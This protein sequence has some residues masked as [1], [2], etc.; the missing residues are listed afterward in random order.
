[1]FTSGIRCGLRSFIFDR[2]RELGAAERGAKGFCRHFGGGKAGPPATGSDFKAGAGFDLASLCAITVAVAGLPKEAAR[3][4][5]PP[6]EEE[7]ASELF[8]CTGIASG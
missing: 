4:A 7:K 5:A 2:T 6:V 1:M 8:Y 3:G